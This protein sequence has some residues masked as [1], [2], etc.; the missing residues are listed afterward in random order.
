MKFKSFLIDKTFFIITQAI[1]LL[2]ICTFLNIMGLNYYSIIF[3]VILILIAD[4][5]YLVYDFL[6]KY[7]FYS[8]L[9]K[10]IESIDK[11]YLLSEIINRPNFEE[12]KIFYNVFKIVS[13]SM[14]DEI[15]KY[16]N[17]A[18]EYREFIETWVHEI[19]TPIAASKLLIENN[20]NKITQSLNEEIDKIDAFVE[21]ALFYSRSNTLE[22]DYI[23]KEVLLSDIV[24]TAVK[25]HS[26]SLIENKILLRLNNL[27]F[28][29]YV[30]TKW[31]DFILGQIIVNSIKYKSDN[32]QLLFYAEKKDNSII[33]TIE[34]NGIGICNQDLNR[35]FE[36]G[37]T[38]QNGRNYSKS[39][40]L[41]LYLCKKLCNKMGIGIYIY[42]KI[43]VGTKLKIIF[44]KSTTYHF[45]FL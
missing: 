14:N 28:N 38:G 35:V 39:T 5:S 30:D 3:F 4:I 18:Y 13:K 26:K 15:G 37:F 25:K 33:L 29:I 40:G 36:K 8:D 12:G 20:K 7:K 10:N 31:I 19:K 6:L 45:N 11:K 27:D 34:D 32:S 24:K 9:Q 16:K 22:K 23:I 44:P 21:Q 1:S 42:S 2:I 43:N 17:S 41:G